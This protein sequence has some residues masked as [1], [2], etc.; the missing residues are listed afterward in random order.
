MQTPFFRR[1][2]DMFTR[3]KHAPVNLISRLGLSRPE[4][5]WLVPTRV[6]MAIGWLRAC[7]EK[8][9]DPHWSNGETLRVFLESQQSMIAFPF[10]SYLVQQLFITHLKELAFIVLLG[11]WLVGLGILFGAWTKIALLAGI[12]MNFNF[13]LLGRPDPSAFYIVIQWMLLVGRADR[14]MSLDAFL[15]QKSELGMTSKAY[16]VLTIVLGL[17]AALLFPF[18]QS[19]APA[20][21]VKDPVAVLIVLL[22]IIALSTAFLALQKPLTFKEKALTAI[23]TVFDTLF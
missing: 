22:V 5:A 6:F 20:Q 3:T 14:V 11:Q 18:I 10:Y 15:K 9:A 2:L 17:L 23:R 4:A 19:F 12:F 16:L 7:A 8:L 13:L 21:S 1:F